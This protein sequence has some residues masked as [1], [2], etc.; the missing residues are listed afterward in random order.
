MSR[1]KETHPLLSPEENDQVQRLFETYHQVAKAL[2]GSANQ[3]QA[4][5]ALSAVNSLSEA[6]Q[7]AFLKTLAK[8]NDSDAADVLVAINTLS[9]HKEVRKEARRSLIRLEATKTYPQWTPPIAHTSAVQ[10]NIA[11][12]PRFWKGVV[13]Q[14]REEGEVQLVLCWEQG[15]DY[16]EARAL[17]LL[18][19]FW[20]DGVKDAT[21]E[22]STK[23]RIDERINYMRSQLSDAE[24]VDCT[25]AEGKRLIEEALSVNNWRGT[26]PAKEYRNHLS[27]INS[28]IMQASDLGED[29]G[30]TFINPELE[31]QE[32]VI[33]FLGAWTMGDYALA[34]DLLSSS[35]SIREDL[36]RDEWIARHRA[37]ADEAHPARME[38]GFVRERER[39]QSALWLPTPAIGSNRSLRKEVE[40]G[41][42]VELVDTPLSG[43]LNE[44]PMG[45]AINKETG[46]H[47]FWT[48]YTLVR[49]HEEWRIQSAT[50][51]GANIQGLSITELQ[52]R[53]KDDEDAIDSLDQRFRQRAEP[54]E[55]LIEEVSWRFTQLLHYYDALIARLPLDRQVYEDAYARAV[56]GGNAER[57]MVYLER[58]AQRF[59]EGR[60]ETLR[61][62]GSTLAG[63]AY[64]P[65]TQGVEGRQ[66]HLL[67][68]AEEALRQSVD[69]NDIALGHILLGELLLSMGQNDGA[70]AELLKAR[71]MTP[72]PD[73]EA[74]IEAGLG[75]IAIRRERMEEALPHYRRVAEINPDYPGIW[76][77]LGFAHRLSGHMDEAEASYQ[78]AIQLEPAD[79][80][81][82]GEL[83]A[84]YMNRPD[85]QKAREIIELGLRNNPNSAHLHALL[86]SILFTMGDR[87]GAQRQI[88]EAEEI[89]PELDI[90]KSVREFMN[91][92]KKR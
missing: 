23:R 21:M 3:N 83:A 11:N 73:D 28:L 79:T 91:T 72:A 15:Y 60:G 8:E 90:V 31:E 40:I 78:R 44:M 32:V 45:T 10:V 53:I 38:L 13:T 36:P 7:V 47:W 1:K 46:R 80:R 24:L 63:L 12:P 81:P 34:Y 61:R 4:E 50:D 57:M 58:I 2:H 19:D 5:E 39:S 27:L 87:R 66:Q 14:T 64:T 65:Q 85:E 69:V 29:R 71:A 51:E 33:N 22:T 89:D 6:A 52:K 35:S 82:Y 17:A 77:N 56:V 9:P 25:L 70:E 62:L 18:L 59:A 92:A 75:N 76:F 54:P 49:E 88:E 16:G 55:A 30:R 37:W 68:R 41:W 86:A 84:I 67:A 48:S 26:A 20:H 74:S 42:S 43:T